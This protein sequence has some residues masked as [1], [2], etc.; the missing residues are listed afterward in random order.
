[1]FL[2]VNW[3]QPVGLS[4]CLSVHVCVKF[5][6]PAFSPFSRLFLKDLIPRF[7]KRRHFAVKGCLLILF[8]QTRRFFFCVC[9]TKSFEN[10]VSKGEITISPF[11][12]AFSTLSENFPPFLSNLKLVSA[13]SFKRSK[14][15]SFGLEFHG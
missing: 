2:R 5:W 7:F 13:N 6:L 10:S 4:V 14:I 1:M 3:N 11:L 15:L 8:P 9:S 12:K